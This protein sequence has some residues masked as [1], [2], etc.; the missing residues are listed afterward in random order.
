MKVSMNDGGIGKKL[1]ELSKKMVEAQ[2]SAALEYITLVAI[3]SEMKYLTGPQPTRLG[4]LSGNLVR[5]ILG[6]K[7][8]GAYDAG[9]VGQNAIRI[10]RKVPGGLKVEYG[11]K[12]KSPKGFDYPEYWEY[13]GS[14]KGHG[15]PRPFLFPATKDI[16][17]K[18]P[19]ILTKHTEQLIKQLG[20]KEF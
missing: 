16:E 5:S 19:M 6:L 20:L 15:G 9:V 18:L 7:S 2:K 4:R 3:R 11:T 8:T 17:P 10:M 1:E 12:Q 14:G 13:Y